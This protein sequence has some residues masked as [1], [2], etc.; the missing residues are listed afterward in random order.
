MRL[1]V[2]VSTGGLSVEAIVGQVREAAEAG[3]DSAYFN[4]VLSWD[5]TGLAMLSASQVPG[6]EVGT[7]VTPTYPRHPLAL[8]SQALTAQAASGNRFTL[9][10]GPSHRPIIEAQF[11]YSYDRPARHVREYLAALMPLLRG[12]QVDYH[13][14]VITAAGQVAVPGARAP[15]VLLAALGPVMLKIA[16]EL[17]DGTV[18]VWTGPQAIADH[19]APAITR[20]AASAGRPA[21]RIVADVIVVLT[22]DAAGARER[23][24]AT[25]GGAGQF[26]SYRSLLDRQGMSGIHETAITGDERVIERAVR[27]YAEAGATE[28]VASLH[29]SEQEKARTLGLLS[30]L[31]GRA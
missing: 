10:I 28:L 7:A 5:A 26:A 3:L 31:R 1:G 21:P 6:I 14:E 4:Q 8:A 22:A 16:G 12:E 27:A 17:A 11:G 25:A 13:G 19:I 15:S 9:G 29:G 30:A 20:A 18:T 23:I 2:Q 24:A